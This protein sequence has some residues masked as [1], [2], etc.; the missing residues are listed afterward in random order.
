[1]GVLLCYNK[2]VI[3]LNIYRISLLVVS[4]FCL[5]LIIV[6]IIMHQKL[7]NDTILLSTENNNDRNNALTMMLETDVDSNEYE[8]ATSNEWPEE[9]YIF[10][11]EMSACETGW[12]TFLG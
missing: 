6:V 10:N 5:T 4:L 2:L 12:Y 8:V 1:M 3:I 9:G 11:A 7:N